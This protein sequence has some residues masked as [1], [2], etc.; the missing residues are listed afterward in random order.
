MDKRVALLEQSQKDIREELHSINSNITRL[1]W[2]V[3]GAVVV[4]VINLVI[5]SNGGL[6]GV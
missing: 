6:P 1:V 4:G 5:R 2:I 3:V